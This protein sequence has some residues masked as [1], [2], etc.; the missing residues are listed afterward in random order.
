[1]RLMKF[2]NNIAIF[3]FLLGCISI[4]QTFQT[5]ELV[6][7][8]TTGKISAGLQSARLNVATEWVSNTKF[9]PHFGDSILKAMAGA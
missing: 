3:I 1:M 4:G 2:K 9:E 8:G 6:I 7:D 5:N